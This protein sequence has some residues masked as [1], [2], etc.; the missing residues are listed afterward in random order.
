MRGYADN[1]VT[2]DAHHGQGI[3]VITAPDNKPFAGSGDDFA[4]FLH[5]AASVLDADDIID[6]AQFDGRLGRNTDYRSGRNIVQ[7][8]GQFGVLGDGL[9]MQVKTVLGRFII[10][11]R[12][13]Q[14][15]RQLPLSQPPG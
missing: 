14:N 13:Q 12:Y 6:L 15:K 5:I 2:T 9:K 11:G 7:N 8:A 10:I 4:G 1:T 3:G